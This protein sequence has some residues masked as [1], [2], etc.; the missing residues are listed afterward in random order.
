[1]IKTPGSYWPCLIATLALGVVWLFKGPTD[2]ELLA[3]VA[4]AMDFHPWSGWWSASFLGG[5]SQAPGLTTLLTYLVLKAFILPFGVML[6]SKLASLLAVFLGGLGIS[7]LLRR[8]TGDETAAWVGGVAYILGPQMAL[9][10][11]GNEHLPVVFSMVFAPWVLW[12]LSGLVR[13][14]SW[15]NS[16]IVAL[17]SAGMT[18]TFTK[19]A[20]AFAPLALLF[21]GYLWMSDLEGRKSLLNG[22]LR[23]LA[24]FVPLAV[25]PLL[26]TL[27][28]VQWLAMFQFDP[29]AAWQQ[30]FS[31]KSLVSWLD[32]G[33]ALQQ[34]MSPG[35]TADLGGFYVGVVSLAVG[36]FAWWRT[37]RNEEE[38]AAAQ[39]LLSVLKFVFG[40]LLFVSWMSAGPRC[41]AQGMLEF[42]KSAS[43]APDLTIPLFWLI[44]AGQCALLWMIWPDHP[45]TDWGRI[46]AILVFL[47]VPGFRLYELLPFAHDI[48]APWSVWQVGGSLA[49]AL[50]FGVGVA[51][52][53]RGRVDEMLSSGGVAMLLVILLAGDYSVYLL[54]YGM[55]AMAPATYPAFE[56]IC[57]QL[58]QAPAGSVYPLSGR[59]FYLQIP[60]LTGKPIEQEA[61][62]GYFGLEWRRTL[63]NASMASP[64]TMRTGL[65]L[66]GCSYI[67]IDKQDPNTPAN[68]QQTFR[69]LFPVLMENEY[70]VVLANQG[71][72][73][74]AFLAHDFVALPKD[75]YVMA[76]AAVQLAPQ[77]LITVEMTG[78]DRSMPGF[79]GMAKGPNQIELLQQYQGKAGQPFARVPLVGNRMDNYQRITY[80]LPPTA[81]GWLV[82]TEAY[83]PDWTVTIDGKPSEVHRA[84]AALLSAYVPQGSHEVVFQFKAPVWYYFCLSLG[85][86]SWIIALAALIYLPSK[87]APGKWRERWLT[88]QVQG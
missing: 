16:L 11:A 66:L 59:Y 47:G 29:F 41:I 86:L 49:V 7:A 5:A 46:A 2:Q 63:Q 43:N 37:S 71:A 50:L 27:R 34:G 17:L 25:I 6:G 72:L 68:L 19:L 62:N 87:Y 78:V 1:M 13:Q 23:S 21:V 26:P 67:F 15:K 73:Y 35:F 39:S 57:A 79:A 44:A 51:L 45:R 85:A 83:H 64:D 32:R 88:S 33:N 77:N 10:L 36:I 60:A 80:Q 75:S 53:L 30:N 84:E 55:G 58:R 74:P 70:F 65:S 20:V 76:P 31:L 48:R 24:L 22:L 9:R 81:S 18:L 28:E 3:N 38:D 69:A 42:L 4:K 12:A 40:M 8:W 52:L 54:R 14:P 82:V 61:F 56:Q